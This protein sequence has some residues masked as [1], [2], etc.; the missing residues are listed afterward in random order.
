MSS[1]PAGAGESVTG[2]ATTGFVT[3]TAGMIFGA[4]VGAATAG[5]GAITG[6]GVATGA[7]GAANAVKPAPDR[8][9]GKTVVRRMLMIPN[10]GLRAGENKTR[11]RLF[12]PVFLN[13][14]S[15]LL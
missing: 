12:R 1:T 9:S 3:M 7:A 13:I 14:G 5:R 8:A 15:V 4:P 11:A 10:L 2:G 6:A